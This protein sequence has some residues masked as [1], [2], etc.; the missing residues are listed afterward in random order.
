MPI[1]NLIVAPAV[2]PNI[3]KG[4]SNILRYNLACTSLITIDEDLED[5]KTFTYL[6]T[7]IDEHSGSDADVKARIV[8]ARAAYLQL[9]NI[10]NSKQLSTD[11]KVRIFNTNVKTVLLSKEE[12]KTK[13]YITPRNGDRN[14]KNEQQLDRTG[15]EC[16]GQFGLENAGRWPML[17]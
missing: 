13:E 5:V 7:M 2:G 14:K 4:K 16:P 3:H 12:R 9:K 10:W 15:K 11:T 6:G 1:I 17:H 8:K